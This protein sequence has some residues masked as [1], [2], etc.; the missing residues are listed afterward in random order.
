METATLPYR[1][2]DCDTHI[3]E[4]PDA[5]SRYIEPKFRDMAAQFNPGH[6]ND[7]RIAGKKLDSDTIEMPANT[8]MRP[9]S[10]RDY[11][12]TLVGGADAT[13]YDY[14]PV[15]DWH[16]RREPRLKL[17][18][19]QNMEAC[20]LFPNIALFLDGHVDDPAVAQANMHAFN[21]WFDEEW[22]FNYQDRIYAS[23]FISLRD[24]DRAVQEVEWA[25]QR[26]ARSFSMMTGHAAG[27]S[28]ADP[29]FDPVW[30][31]INEAKAIVCYH[32]TDSGYNREL[33]GN[34]SE[35]PD[36]KF[37]TQS[38]WQW[39]NCYCDRAMMETLSSLIFGN[40]FGR[41]P[42]LK[43]ISVEHGIEWFPYFVKR[44]D[45]MR[46]MGR[47]G[48]WIGG[49]L[50]ERPSEIIK[51]HVTVTPFPEDDVAAV[52]DAL[53]GVESIALGSDFPHAEGLA[54]PAWFT[55]RLGGLSDGDVRK[56]MRDNGR[57]FLPA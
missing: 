49:P 50:T 55:Q 57:R 26:G 37:F 13:D 3:L 24:C 31:R 21:Q 32:L 54:Q 36:A 19:E 16:M 25:L 8:T 2:F 45:K 9:G 44:M 53:G 10:L 40:L 23:P 11:Y 52:A 39:M 43:V 34:W 15:Q 38:A 35:R 18:D 27:R 22:G 51:R 56:I 33:S 6:P 14:M 42:N 28:P 7:A 30:S 20:L 1:I 47:G 46:G 29:H 48:Q 41:F 17:M 5:F 4:Q 12:A